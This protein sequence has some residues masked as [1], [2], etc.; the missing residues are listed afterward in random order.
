MWVMGRGG[1]WPRHARLLPNAGLCAQ[2]TV[3]PNKTKCQSLEQRKVYCRAKQGERV[4]C[5]QNPKLPEGFQQSIFR[6]Q[7]RAGAHRVGDQFM[8]NSLIG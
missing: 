7:V 2:H 4:A 1:H 3:R 8:H 5:A 6:S